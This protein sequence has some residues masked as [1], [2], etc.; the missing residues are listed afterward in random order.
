MKPVILQPTE[1]SAYNDSINPSQ[2]TQ[3]PSPYKIT[4]L[5][6]LRA[7]GTVTHAFYRPYVLL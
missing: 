6:G 5:G 3:T 1:A 7:G 4:P 2:W